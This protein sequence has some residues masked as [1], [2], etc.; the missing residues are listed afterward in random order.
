MI[1]ERATMPIGERRRL[2][3]CVYEKRG[4]KTGLT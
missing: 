3:S 1:G 4:A 2:K